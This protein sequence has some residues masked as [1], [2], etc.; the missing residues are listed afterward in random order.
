MTISAQSKAFVLESIGITPAGRSPDVTLL[1][2]GR[3]VVVWQEVL[4]TPA[5]GFTDTD[6]AIFARI[7]NADGTA[8]G[9]AI[10]VNLW[11][12]GAQAAP[13]VAATK[14]GGFIVS[15][16]STLT[17]GDAPTD[18]DNFAVAFDN[19]GAQRPLLDANE[20][21]IPF[22]DIDPDN[23]GAAESGSF[24]VDLGEGYVAFVQ[25]ADVGTALTTVN[26][27]G[28]DG[29]LA[30]T[31]NAGFLGA[32]D[33]VTDVARLDS[34]NIVIAGQTDDV[35]MLRISDESLIAAPEG[36]PGLIGPVSFATMLALPEANDV[37]VTA[38]HP[39]A[40]APNPQGGGFVVTALQPA[41]AVASTLVMESFTAWGSKVGSGS[42]NIAI[43][44]N[45]AHPDYD[46]LAMQDGTFV[47]AWTTR[48]LNGIDIQVGHFDSDGTALGASVVVQGGAAAGDQ[49]GPQLSEMADG[50]VMVVYTD[51]GL[52]PINGAVEPLHAVTLTLTSTSG[53]F[54]ASAG[55]DTLN[56]TGG[57]DGIDGLAGNDLIAGLAG[58]DA[59]YGGD[60]NDSLSGGLGND[61]L[62]GGAGADSLQG[63]DGGD[64]LAGGAG[65]DMLKGDAGN[66]ALS[67]GLNGDRL[68]GG[69][70]DD[71]LDGG[72]GNDVLR[73][74]AGN[75]VFVFRAGGGQD[76]VSDFGATDFLRL[77]HAL[78]AALG[79]LTAAQVLT[80]FA[81]V[82]GGD[83]VLTFAGGETITLQGFT[84]LAAGDLQL[85]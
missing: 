50:R 67:G 59:L 82:A 55:N 27:M 57:H 17:W 5:D 52:N 61:G 34:G 28:S 19:T 11:S 35:V 84:A 25:E 43:S 40:S 7:Y 23:P 81:T 39:G 63:G 9:E 48:G 22:I 74:D 49:V 15:F 65:S 71:R 51:L 4:G 42:I 20:D 31:V 54:P 66:D 41:G 2:D 68:M 45:N 30:G 13:S 70:G 8:A 53:G 60:G 33:R 77:D 76:R 16:T 6:G 56:G 58:S 32:F 46:V 18:I 73:G 69:D 26:L 80:N 37:R 12:P 36:I 21:P 85:I 62:I 64:G 44:L 75:D 24:M 38:L 1:A 3:F 14:D 78:W 72:G 47:V 83:T 10:Q 29:K 79:D